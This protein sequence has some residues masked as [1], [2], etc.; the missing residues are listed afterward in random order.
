MQ[1]EFLIYLRF[2]RHLLAC[3]EVTSYGCVADVLAVDKNKK[4]II[5]YEFKRTSADLRYSEKKKGKYQQQH[6]YVRGR[7]CVRAEYQQPHRFYFVIPEAL[8]NKERAYLE[9]QDCGVIVWGKD[10]R[11]CQEFRTAKKCM[12]RKK[13]L[14]KYDVVVKDILQRATSA[15]VRLLSMRDTTETPK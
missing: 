2:K 15:Y 3:D 5:E 14:Q 9:K 13:N 12:T 1:L 4:H 10:Y 6:K 8:W 11:S 7:Y